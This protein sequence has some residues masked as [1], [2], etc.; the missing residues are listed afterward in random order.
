MVTVKMRR[1]TASKKAEKQQKRWKEHARL[2]RIIAH[3]VRL[4][5]LDALSDCSCCVKDLNSLVPVSQPHLSQHMAALRR[6]NLVQCYSSGTLRCY[7]ILQP[8]LIRMLMLLLSADHPVRKRERHQVVKEAVGRS[9]EAAEQKS[10]RSGASRK[11]AKRR[12]VAPG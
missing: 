4:M 12:A 1:A 6:A 3:P 11:R 9:R 8:T 5:I 2:L 10:K 7:Y